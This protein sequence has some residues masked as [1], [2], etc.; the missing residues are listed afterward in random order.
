MFNSWGLS[1]N[2]GPFAAIRPYGWFN[3]FYPTYGFYTPY[4]GY[5]G[6]NYGYSYMPVFLGNATKTPGV[7]RP[8]LGGYAN[9]NY[10][11]SNNRNRNTGRYMPSFNSNGEGRYNNRSNGFS[12]NNNNFNRSNSGNSSSAPTRSFSPSSSGGSSSGGSSGGGVT[13]QPRR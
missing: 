13:R 5:F 12:N 1:Y 4:N 10:N 2:Y 6:H 9:N 7:R 8:L 11:N 3:S